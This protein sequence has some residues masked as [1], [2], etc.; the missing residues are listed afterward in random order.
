MSP[1]AFFGRPGAGANPFINP[2]VGAPVHS[3]TS[4][5]DGDTADSSISSGMGH[6]CQPDEAMGYFPPVPVEAPPTDDAG[7]FPPMSLPSG[8]ASEGSKEAEKENGQGS[9]GGWLGEMQTDAVILPSPLE[10]EAA[11]TVGPWGNDGGSDGVA[12]KQNEQV[13]G[14]DDDGDPQDSS[15]AQGHSRTHSLSSPAKAMAIPAHRSES[16]PTQL[17]TYCNMVASD[18]AGGDENDSEGDRRLLTGLGL[19]LGLGV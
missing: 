6:T 1:G 16:D 12:G 4:F 8:S 2:A 17:Q 3:A 5:F 11:A 9:G 18:E 19:G 14:A 15:D 10:T 13:Q 7:Y